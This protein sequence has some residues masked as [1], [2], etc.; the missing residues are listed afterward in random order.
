M[1]I[2]LHQI[3]TVA[4]CAIAALALAA[5]FSPAAAQTVSDAATGAVV[6]DVPAPAPGASNESEPVID[7]VVSIPWGDIAANFLTALLSAVGVVAAYLLR[8]LPAGVVSMLDGLA[9]ALLQKRASELLEFALTYGINTTAGA[10]RGKTLDVKV[11]LEV[12]ERALEYAMRHAPGLVNSL[13]GAIALR[14]K[15]I[16]RLDLEESAGQPAP[17]PPPTALEALS[18]TGTEGG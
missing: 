1:K 4:L 3:G 10:A 17:K 12:L 13:G 15:I 11:G 2:S 7:G 5:V 14:E 9:G 6:Y 16:A 8:K 18:G